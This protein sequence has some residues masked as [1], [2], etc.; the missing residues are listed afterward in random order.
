MPR[1]HN[2]YQLLSFAHEFCVCFIELLYELPNLTFCSTRFSLF[3]VFYTGEKQLGF[4]R[5][6]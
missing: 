4:L 2:D 3:F 1:H 6:V 5:D